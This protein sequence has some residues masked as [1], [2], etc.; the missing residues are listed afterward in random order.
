M[1][2]CVGRGWVC[3]LY[4]YKVV[5]TEKWSNR[6]YERITSK[7]KPQ[8]CQLACCEFKR[9]IFTAGYRS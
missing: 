2:A 5:T 1:N 4:T 3:M 9:E 6:K 7:E 8:L